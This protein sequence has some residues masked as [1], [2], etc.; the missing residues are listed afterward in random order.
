VYRRRVNNKQIAWQ[1][2][3]EEKIGRPKSRWEDNSKINLRVTR[4][5]AVGSE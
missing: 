4:S 5:E 1:I 3:S 2:L